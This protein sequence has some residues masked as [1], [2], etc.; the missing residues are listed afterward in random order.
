MPTREQL[1][2]SNF[3]HGFFTRKDAEASTVPPRPGLGRE[4]C[5]VLA[6]SAEYL[7]HRYKLPVP[8][9]DRI[10]AVLPRRV[11]GAHSAC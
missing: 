4:W 5:A 3:L 2:W 9:L 11:V 1:D 8:K 10:A 6:G 7:R